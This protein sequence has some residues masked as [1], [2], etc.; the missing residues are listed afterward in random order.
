MI[1]WRFTLL[2]SNFDDNSMMLIVTHSASIVY[3]IQASVVTIE[4][5]FFSFFSFFFFVILYSVERQ[6]VEAMK[7]EENKEH[8][9]KKKPLTT[10]NKMQ[11]HFLFSYAVRKQTSSRIWSWQ[12]R[13]I[14]P[15]L[16]FFLLFFFS[17]S[18]V[19]QQFITTKR[20]RERK[21]ERNEGGEN[22]NSETREKLR[23]C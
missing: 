12:R 4:D 17:S 21:K 9:P 22:K 2:R 5:F 1:H 14:T 6:P 10:R 16:K 15:F 18:L 23:S 7:Y 8:L 20:E 19:W 11:R 13:I 3:L